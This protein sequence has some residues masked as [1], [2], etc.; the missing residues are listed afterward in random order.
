MSEQ[1]YDEE[2]DTA[3]GEFREDQANWWETEFSEAHLC[4]MIPAA[5]NYFRALHMEAQ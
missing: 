4:A 2:I 1:I 5:E 3:R